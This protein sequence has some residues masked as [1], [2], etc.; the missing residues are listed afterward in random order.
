MARIQNFSIIITIILFS[1]GILVS[2]NADAASWVYKKGSEKLTDKQYSVAF[3]FA[4]DYEYNND[5][6]VAFQCAGEKVRFE[7]NAYSLNTSKGKD[8]AFA[9]RV[10]KRDSRQLILRTFSNENQGGYT[11]DNVR[12]IAKAIFG[13]NKLFVRAFTGNND[14]LEAMISLAGSD[15]AIRKVFSDCGVSLDSS[16]QSLKSSYSMN[17]F[18]SSFKKLTPAQQQT[19]L[20]ELKELMRKY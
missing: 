9:Y 11:Y 20:K 17:D 15:N 7:I 16:A 10:D 1:I 8:F 2:S 12:R 3:G 13:G 6:S 14:Y 18:I 19:V 5:F 4:P